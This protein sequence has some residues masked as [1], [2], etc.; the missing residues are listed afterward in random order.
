MYYNALR[1]AMYTA[2]VGKRVRS[3]S[4]GL[5]HFRTELDMGRVHS[6]IGFSQ[7]G[8][9]RVGSGSVVWV[10]MFALF[11]VTYFNKIEFFA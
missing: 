4:L 2:K 1:Y 6:R 7:V 11:E 9:S 5:Y 10:C 8:F 3:T